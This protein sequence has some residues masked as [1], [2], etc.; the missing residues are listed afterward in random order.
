MSNSIPEIVHILTSD[1]VTAIQLSAVGSAVCVSMGYGMY[2]II[3]MKAIYVL[4][5]RGVRGSRPRSMMLAVILMIFLTTTIV[6]AGDI[7]A[8]V[9]EVVLIGAPSISAPSVQLF[10][11]VYL[12]A[13]ALLLLMSD[14]VVVWRAWVIC[15]RR[16]VKIALSCCM[17]N[18]LITSVIATINKVRSLAPG[19]SP[20]PT[21]ISFLTVPLP[22]LITNV[23]A[24]L[25]IGQAAW[26]GIR[27]HSQDKHPPFSDLNHCPQSI[28]ALCS[29][30]IVVPHSLD[31]PYYI[32]LYPVGHC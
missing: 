4:I 5:R 28:D 15:D 6:F 11:F 8:A 32:V 12:A 3:T 1:Q 30:W 24:T 2:L 31:H 17:V 25:A 18:G 26:Q 7:Q 13:G 16:W 29:V 20:T 27:A 10:N 19:A 21:F 9:E 23:T 14:A 22:M